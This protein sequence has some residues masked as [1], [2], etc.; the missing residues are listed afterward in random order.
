MTAR[1]LDG[2]ALAATIKAEL[3]DRVATLADHGFLPGLGTLY[4]D[5][6]T[7]QRDLSSPTITKESSS[8]RSS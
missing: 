3:R 2:K 6:T 4:V 5:P 7:C 8:A 1:I